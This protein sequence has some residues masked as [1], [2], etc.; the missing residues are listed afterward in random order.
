MT[1]NCPHSGPWSSAISQ[2]RKNGATGSLTWKQICCD[3]WKPW[4]ILKFVEHDSM[5][6]TRMQKKAGWGWSWGI[7]S[8]SDAEQ[9][10]NLIHFRQPSCM[11]SLHQRGKTID[12]LQSSRMRLISIIINESMQVLW[13]RRNCIALKCE[14]RM[15]ANQTPNFREC[16]A[17]KQKMLL[18][19]SPLLYLAT[20]PRH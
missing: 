6:S 15:R 17:K 2:D 5:I 7:A 10:C 4:K 3:L 13:C 9:P 11:T 1:H 12:E 19:P 14:R 20:Y 16:S 8:L 18:M